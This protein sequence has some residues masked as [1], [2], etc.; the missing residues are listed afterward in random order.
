MM[1]DSD[2]LD[3]MEEGFGMLQDVLDRFQRGLIEIRRHIHEEPMS[4]DYIDGV[5]VEALGDSLVPATD[6]LDR[7]KAA[8]HVGESDDPSDVQ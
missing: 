2:R 1:S 8:D 5:V 6:V 3:H 4:E 7:R